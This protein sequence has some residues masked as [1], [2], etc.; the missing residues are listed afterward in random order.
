MHY[1][2]ENMFN[3]G[4]EGSCKPNSIDC[5]I[6]DKTSGDCKSCSVPRSL[7]KKKDKNG[8]TVFY[9]HFDYGMW[10]VVLFLI[11][12][13]PILVILLYFFCCNSSK[14]RNSRQSEFEMQDHK[15]EDVPLTNR[16]IIDRQENRRD[17]MF[18]NHSLHG[19]HYGQD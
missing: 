9:C 15:D 19:I 18:S 5:D 14:K 1:V 11:I 7:V 8:N 4:T 12:F 13:I 2:W 16:Q 10:V 3:I 6:H 17:R